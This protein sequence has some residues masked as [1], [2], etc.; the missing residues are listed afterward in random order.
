MASVNGREELRP[1]APLSERQ[2]FVLCKCNERQRERA[3]LVQ[4][5]VVLPELPVDP[6]VLHTLPE[7]LWGN[8]PHLSYLYTM[9]G[10]SNMCDR[11][12]A[13]YFVWLVRSCQNLASATPDGVRLVLHLEHGEGN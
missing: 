6:G 8:I 7:H 5:H 10:L 3:A 11:N 12:P 2:L 9:D 1:H 13:Q 4:T